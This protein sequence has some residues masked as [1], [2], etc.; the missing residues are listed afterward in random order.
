MLNHLSNSNGTLSMESISEIIDHQ[1]LSRQLVEDTSDLMVQHTL[2]GRTPSPAS[3]VTVLSTHDGVVDE[4]EVATTSNVVLNSDSGEHSNMALVHNIMDHHGSPTYQ[5]Q[6]L[7]QQHHLHQ[8]QEHNIQQHH[9]HQHLSL[10]QRLHLD[11][12]VHFV[13]TDNTLDALSVGSNCSNTMGHII[14]VEQEHKLVIVNGNS[15]GSSSNNNNN[16]NNICNNHK[17]N[18]NNSINSDHNKNNCDLGVVLDDLTNDDHT[19]MDS[20][21]QPSYE[22]HEA[23]GEPE[24]HR[25]SS[26]HHMHHH[27]QQRSRSNIHDHSSLHSSQ[28]EPLTV[29]VQNHDDSRDSATQI[30]S[31]PELSVVGVGE[32]SLG[33][34][35]YQ[36]LTSVVNDEPLSPPGFSPTSAYATL[37]PLQPLPPISTMSEKFAYG[38]HISGGGV[39]SSSSTNDA[40][41]DD[42]GNGNST[43]N[44][45]AGVV[46]PYVVMPS[47]HHSHNQHQHSQHHHSHQHHSNPLSS[48]SLSGLSGGEPSPYSSYDKLPT[49]GMS[50]T[51]PHNYGSSPSH[52]LSGLVVSCDLPETSPGGCG[53]LSPQSPYS[54]STATEL[55]SPKPSQSNLLHCKESSSS[56]SNTITSDS[57]VTG[58]VAQQQRHVVC[59]SSVN[60][61]GSSVVGDHVIV[62]DYGSP[63]NSQQRDLIVSTNPSTS[64]A[65]NVVG[66]N[67]S[68]LQLQPPSPGVLSPHSVSASSMNSPGTVVTLPHMNNNGS[69][70]LVDISALQGQQQQH[71]VSLTPS[72][73]PTQSIGLNEV[74]Q[75]LLVT[76]NHGN[77]ENNVL[78]GRRLMINGSSLD[79]QLIMQTTQQQQDLKPHPI[80]SECSNNGSQQI[81]IQSQQ[82]QQQQTI[83]NQQ[84]QNEILPRNKHS[85]TNSNTSSNTNNTSTSCGDMEEINT[86]ELAQ[87]ISA[88]LKRYSIPQAIFAQ[89]VLC[90]SQGTLS[91]LL[92]NP[93]PWS[94]LKSGRETFRRMFKWLQ[95]PEFQ[96]MSALRMAAAQLPQRSSC[97]TNGNSSINHHI[98]NNSAHDF[99]MDFVG[100][101]SI[102]STSPGSVSGGPLVS[103]GGSCHRKDEPQMEH[104]PQPKKPRL[105]FTDLQRRTLQAIFKETKRP[106]KEMQVTIARQLG[107]EPTTVGNFFMNARR[108]S[109]D[110]WRDDDGNSNIS[111]H[112]GG[113]NSSYQSNSSSNNH[114][115]SLQN[116]SGHHSNSNNGSQ[117]YIN[118]S[119]NNIGNLHLQLSSSHHHHHSSSLDLDDDGD[120][121]LDLVHDDFELS[122]NNIDD[123]Q[124]QKDDML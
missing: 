13:A 46:G 120:M 71:V 84:N 92:R 19:T 102:S 94:K 64:S 107:L 26:L 116:H 76:A 70:S 43:S 31:P 65:S 59:L 51:P 108:R 123:S 89:R 68:H 78:N 117:Q 66:R 105:V 100:P 69:K 12:P 23:S 110:K 63:Y 91:D 99:D 85:I 9:H 111:G 60:I 37:T 56:K 5:T 101:T 113:K 54:H 62:T 57:G 22:S 114:N 93:K 58:S 1:T 55:Q 36:T 6:R 81:V 16:N 53:P 17:N 30:L 82:Q 42:G 103:A 32:N 112:N 45:P 3:S 115:Q 67:G 27:Q 50:M 72:P 95:E 47:T 98:V 4:H 35:S 88:E 48:L 38:G 124:H 14:A 41:S 28:T 75:T 122:D 11:S 104:M 44:G 29:I 90:R 109:M 20:T 25:N 87:R 121:D 73:P 118:N 86:K 34:S 21:D 10:P 97:T 74:P 2:V 79:T 18:N 80:T 106:S 15:N 119:R 39:I 8:Q 40:S 96:R 52:T 83:Q 49:M 24:S 33:T 7:H 61:N 77:D